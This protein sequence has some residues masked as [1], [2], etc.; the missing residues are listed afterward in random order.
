MRKCIISCNVVSGT[1]ST[2]LYILKITRSIEM[3]SV[4]VYLH[5][6][7]EIL[8]SISGTTHTHTIN[9][10][11]PFPICHWNIAVVII[12]Y[13]Q[14]GWVDPPRKENKSIKQVNLMQCCVCFG[15]L[16]QEDQ[17]S[18]L[19]CMFLNCLL[20]RYSRQRWIRE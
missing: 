12:L 4:I 8:T 16:G 20:N 11:G 5:C 18:E 17:G 9:K 6:K 2:L 3:Y 1:N 15:E 19:V 14:N 7:C 13:C 10:A